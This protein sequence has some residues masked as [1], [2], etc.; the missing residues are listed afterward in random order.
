MQLVEYISFDDVRAVLGVSSDEIEDTT[1]SL[2]LYVF[3]L[4]AELEG[5]S[6]TLIP[7][8]DALQEVKETDRTDNDRRFD[9]ALRLFCAYCVANQACG[10]LPMFAPKE[11]SDGKA[12]LTR[13]AQDPYKA[14]IARISQQYEAAKA[15]L[16]AAYGVLDA[17]SAPV[18]TTRPYFV[19]STPTYD[20]ITG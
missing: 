15:A 17:P 14:T 1:L 7:D 11:Q 12:S 16:A 6:L 13:F 20:P 8:Y 4:T 2:D 18:A 10:A 19:V 3:N 5:I 9:R